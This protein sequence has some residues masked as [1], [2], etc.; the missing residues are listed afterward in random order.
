[1]PTGPWT[2]IPSGPQSVWSPAC[3]TMPSREAHL[4]LRDFVE[5]LKSLGWLR[6]VDRPV[7]KDWEFAC[8]ARWA[9]E[10]TGEDDAYAI[11]FNHV[12]G[13]DV[14]VVVGLFASRRHIARSLGVG[15]DEILERWARALER[16]LPPQIVTGGLTKGVVCRGGDVDLARLPIP[17]WT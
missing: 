12:I 3:W 2:S 10:S 5:D 7:D 9:L 8:I 1:M 14:P 17:I 4:R 16:P 6:E 11:R 13:H 15:T